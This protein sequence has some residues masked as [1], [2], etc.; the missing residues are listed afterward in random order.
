MRARGKVQLHMH[1]RAHKH[2]RSLSARKLHSSCVQQQHCSSITQ[3]CV[4]TTATRVRYSVADEQYSR[5]SLVNIIYTWAVVFA[6]NNCTNNDLLLVFPLNVFQYLLSGSTDQ[7]SLIT[8]I[9][10]NNPS[11]F[12]PQNL[13]FPFVCTS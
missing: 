2:T 13:H 7:F 3:S 5:L 9:Y 12:C 1:A 10:L 6:S 4:P 11:E 8:P